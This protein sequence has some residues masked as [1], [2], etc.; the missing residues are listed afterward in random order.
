[1]NTR[2][3]VPI[4]GWLIGLF[5]LSIVAIE[6][7]LLLGYNQIIFTVVPALQAVNVYAFGH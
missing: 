6:P 5:A 7:L 1:M 2:S 3:T 4:F